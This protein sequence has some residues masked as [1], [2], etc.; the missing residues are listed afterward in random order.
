M[1]YH[2]R[3]A[4]AALDIVCTIKGLLL[5]RLGASGNLGNH[6]ATQPLVL[7][8]TTCACARPATPT[9]VLND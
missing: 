3:D 1:A 9:T 2:S 5:P 7:G 4:S 6:T 8:L